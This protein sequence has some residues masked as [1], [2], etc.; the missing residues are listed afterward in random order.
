MG[1]EKLDVLNREKFIEEVVT[2]AEVTSENKQICCFSINGRWGCGKTYVLDKIE[3]ELSVIQNEETGMDRYFICHYDCW[4]Y[5]YYEEPLIAIIAAMLDATE[6]DKKLLNSKVEDSV[7]IAIALAKKALITLIS[8]FSKNKIGVD[9]A[10][11]IS[12]TLEESGENRRK[13]D[14]KV[15]DSFFDFNKAI[16]KTQEN[17]KKI[18]NTRTIVLIVDELDRCLPVYAIKV[19]ERLHHLF[20]GM[21]NVVMIIAMDK[22]QL[23]HSLMQI[24]GE[25]I[26]TDR[27]LRKFVS[28]ELT[29]NNGEPS[30]YLKKYKTYSSLFDITKIDQNIIE[31]FFKDIFEGIDIRTQEEIFKK[32]ETMHRLVYAGKREDASEMLFEI[33]VLCFME[34]E[35][36]GNLE[37]IIYDN[38]YRSNRRP[39]NNPEFFN[40]IIEYRKNAEEGTQ[41][42]VD[43]R[44]YKAVQG[45]I[46]KVFILAASLYSEMKENRCYPFYIT[47]GKQIEQAHL[48]L[49]KEVY[50]LLCY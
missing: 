10:D 16:H 1:I 25:N 31:T 4:K 3:K 35:K 8:E 45:I 43:G 22:Q 50:K 24:Y 13:C 39:S 27:Y 28:F 18:A 26:D 6:R 40:K 21:T 14:N 36:S 29:L 32:A 2:L 33:L 41:W 5:D 37:C 48:I 20:D 46:G 38:K 7:G 42:I 23:N 17:I 19:L 49:A 44:T 47:N 30:N 11:L 34:K 15:N 12:Q 9:L